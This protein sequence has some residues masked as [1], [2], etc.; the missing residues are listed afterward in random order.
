MWTDGECITRVEEEATDASRRS[1]YVPLYPL[2][3]WAAYHWWSLLA[4]HRPGRVPTKQR[5]Y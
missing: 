1:I 2:A 4:D 5:T 3:E